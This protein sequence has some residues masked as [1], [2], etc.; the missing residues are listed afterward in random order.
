MLRYIFQQ[1]LDNLD[2]TVFVSD[3]GYRNN[4]TD[5]N[6]PTNDQRM[7]VA[8]LLIEFYEL[9]VLTALQ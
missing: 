3:E 1:A 5:S 6:Q 2:L 9:T 4:H 7:D 8:K